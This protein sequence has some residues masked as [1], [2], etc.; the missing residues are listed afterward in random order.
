M[1][2]SKSFTKSIRTTGA[3]GELQFED[4][5]HRDGGCRTTT[6]LDAKDTR[7]GSTLSRLLE[8]MAVTGGDV[9]RLACALDFAK[10]NRV[11]VVV[12]RVVVV[13]VVVV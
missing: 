1:I 5:Y 9:G 4:D 3:R 13:R 6:D 12:A 11:R 8:E 7:V 2:Y 10:H